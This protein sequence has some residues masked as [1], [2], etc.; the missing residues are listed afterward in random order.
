MFQQLSQFW[1]DDETVET[2][3]KTIAKCIDNGGKIALVSCPT[4]YKKMKKN[5]ENGISAFLY[6]TKLINYYNYSEAF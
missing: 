5:F 2:L 4:L 3:T 6:L 1:Y